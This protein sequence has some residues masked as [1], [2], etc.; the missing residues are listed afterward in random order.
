MMLRHVLKKNSG[1]GSRRWFFTV[2]LK[3]VR[4]FEK[5]SIFR[6]YQNCFSI[7]F[8]CV[9]LFKAKPCAFDAS[10]RDESAGFFN[11]F[12]IYFFRELCYEKWYFSGM[13]QPET[14]MCMSVRAMSEKIRKTV[15]NTS[16]TSKKIFFIFSHHNM[17]DKCTEKIS[18]S[19][20]IPLV[21]FGEGLIRTWRGFL[22][23]IYVSECVCVWVLKP[24]NQPS[25]PYL[26]LS[27]FFWN[28]M[29]GTTPN[30]STHKII[31]NGARIRKI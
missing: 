4:D 8:L 16:R 19:G 3:N 6:Y 18:G 1:G 22:T 7:D 9:Y 25:W 12:R 20:E 10:Q 31:L 11:K 15:Y 27:I 26:T 29:S 2:R 5:L 23:S 28:F 30:I 13:A 24:V 14:R 17:T 21:R